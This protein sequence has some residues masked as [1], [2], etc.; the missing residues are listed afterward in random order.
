MDE[1]LLP[2]F[3]NVN[4]GGEQGKYLKEFGNEET[5]GGICLHLSITWLYL[6]HNSTNKAPNTIWQEMKTPTLIQQIASNQRSYQQYYPNIADNV[7]LATRNS[8]HVTGTNAGEIY[9]ITTNALVKSNM[10]L[11]VINLEKDHKPVGRHAIAAIATRG[12]FYLYDPNVGVM[13]VPMPNMK[14]LIEKIPYIYGKHSL[15]ISQT[16]VYNIS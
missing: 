14:E 3:E 10:L 6:W 2:Y 11:Y 12:R 8:L 9:Q 1:K 13:S 7:S 16:S 4:D 5:Q 15:N